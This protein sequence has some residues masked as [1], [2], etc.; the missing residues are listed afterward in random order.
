[1]LIKYK[2]VANTSI[3][4]WAMVIMLGIITYSVSSLK[5][6]IDEAR[7]IG[8]I[9]VLVLKLRRDEKDFLARKS[10]KY[11]QQF[12]VKM[13]NL[14]SVIDSLDTKYRAAGKSLPEI[15][16]LSTILT[17]YHKHFT[18]LVEAQQRIGLDEDSALY[19]EL[20]EAVHHVET[21]LGKKNDKL[22][23]DMLTLR[24]FEKDFM[25]RIKEK[26]VTLWL[27]K[28]HDFRNNI[29]KSELSAVSQQQLMANID[30]YQAA[31]IQLVDAKRELGYSSDIGLMGKM[32]TTVHQVDN[33]LAKLLKTSKDEVTAETEFVNWL[34]YAIFWL[35]L[36]IAIAFAIYLGR[37][38]LLGIN[39]LKDT[40]NAVASSKD[41]SIT[42]KTDGKDELAEMAKVFNAM[43]GS[44]R[45]LINEVNHSVKTVNAATHCLSENIHS[46]NEG[47][48]SQIQQTD[49]V[50]TAVT[51]MVATVEEIS[52]NTHEAADKAQTTFESAKQGKSGVDTTIAKIDQ[53][54]STLLASEHIVQDLAK[55]SDT[56]GSVLDVIRGIA[57]QTNLLA[58]NAAI[59]A[60]RA[61]EQGRGFAVVADEVRTLASRT[62]ESTK[63]IESIIN[64]LQSRTKDMVSHISTCRIQGQSSAE[65]A[66]STGQKLEEITENVSVIMDMNTA[67]ASATQQQ[68]MVA[69]E[70]NQHVVTIR[71]VSEQSGKATHQNA[72]MSEELAQQAEVLHKEVNAFK[73]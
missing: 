37:G 16:E 29:N 38:I 71:D 30:S 20:R 39:Q 28:A 4:I 52:R 59:E 24:R 64:L 11:F 49:L 68:S 53:L 58:L 70:V 8:D 1:M 43:I 5:G 19:G 46:A 60:A 23:N 56:I 65:Q 54:S 51:E 47:V 10:M 67:I 3:L 22:L 17:S 9:E 13:L 55:D 69:A 15:A 35:V 41:L 50:A 2:L 18:A 7:K 33:K 42:C 40:M 45:H 44:F 57:D 25:L 61:G 72:Q 31:F 62:Q 26:Y 66:A 48:D 36:I 14:Q 63:E 73:V 34:S 27:K 6:G 21:L 32:R 12:G